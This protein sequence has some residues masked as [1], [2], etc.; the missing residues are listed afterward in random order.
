MAAVR[1]PSVSEPPPSTLVAKNGRR[2]VSGMAAK[3]TQARISTISR[4]GGKPKA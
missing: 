4:I 3:F 1:R 2:I